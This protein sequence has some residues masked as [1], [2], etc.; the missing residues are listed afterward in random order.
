MEPVTG[1]L[2]A[3][4]APQ[5]HTSTTWVDVHT[6]QHV[7]ME[8]RESTLP[9]EEDAE[10]VRQ[11]AR[12]AQEAWARMNPGPSYTHTPRGGPS[13]AWGERDQYGYYRTAPTPDEAADLFGRRYGGAWRVAD[14]GSW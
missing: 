10:R 7:R 14:P 3:P 2:L 11:A 1:Q 13:P 9:A 8:L 6:G 5:L 12:A 4:A